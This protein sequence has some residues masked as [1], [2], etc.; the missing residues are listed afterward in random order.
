VNPDPC[1]RRG[2]LRRGTAAVVAAAAAPVLR[3]VEPFPH[4]DPPRLRLSLAAYSFRDEFVKAKDGRPPTLDMFGFLDYCAA[5]GCDGAELTSYYFPAD[6]GDEYFIKVRRHA[7]LR[8]VSVSG[9][10]VGNNFTFPKGPERDKEV[11]HVKDWIAKA[12]LLG[13]PHIRVFAGDAKGR[14]APEALRNTIEALEDCADAAAKH[15]IFLGLENHGGIVAESSALLEIVRTVRNPWVGINLDTGNFHTEDPRADLEKCAPYA[16]NVQYKGYLQA[17]GQK[18]Q[19]DTAKA[20][21]DI[22]RHAHYQGWV[23][24]EYELPEP[25]RTKVPEMLRE[26][27]GEL[28]A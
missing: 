4:S 3:A 2:F 12:A 14:P 21:F 20:A 28:A 19:A 5:N 13:A 17:R 25:A 11:A 7:F 16:V 27:R 1:S 9:T 22:L 18:R 10:A 26:M 8:G 15:G 23:A 24:L 6:A